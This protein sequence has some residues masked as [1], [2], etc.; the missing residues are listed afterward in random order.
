MD[1]YLE[2]LD[3]W[4]DVHHRFISEMQTALN[5]NLRPNYVARVE[6][7]FYISDQDDPG[8][9]AMIP[10]VRIEATRRKSGKKH[11]SSNGVALV[12]PLTLPELLD[13]EISEARVEILHRP[14]NTLVTI[15]E[16]L[17]PANKVVNSRGRES[18]IQKRRDARGADVHWLEIDLLRAGTPTV[19]RSALEPSDYRVLLFRARK[20]GKYWPINIQQPLPLIG[21][22]LRDK[23][24]DVPL[25]LNAVLRSAYENAAYDLSI[26]YKREPTPRLKGA[27]KTWADKLLRECG[28]R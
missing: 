26:D 22:P 11:K 13:E 4:P 20:F 25:D 10:D 18:L 16:L 6:T 2:S 9:E 21:V 27:D 3:I 14:T 7:R 28:Q 15:I 19:M 23:D 24:A 5:P 17:S 12:E 8:R 1:P